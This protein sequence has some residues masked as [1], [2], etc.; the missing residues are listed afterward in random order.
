[1]SHAADRDRGLADVSRETLDVVSR[2][3]SG[4]QEP[5]VDSGGGQQPDVGSS[6]AKE[7][8][9]RLMLSAALLKAVDDILSLRDGGSELAWITAWRS[10]ADARDKVHAFIA[11]ESRVD[12]GGGEQPNVGPATVEEWEWGTTEHTHV[13]KV[14]LKEDPFPQDRRVAEVYGRTPEEAEARARLIATAPELLTDCERFVEIQSL[15]RC[16]AGEWSEFCQKIRA[17]VAK[18]RRGFTLIEL[19]VVLVIIAIVSAVALPVIV[20]AWGH[21]QLSEAARTVQG[22]FAGARDDAIHA[23]RPSGY[24]LIPEAVVTLPNGQVD[25]NAPLHASKMIPIRPAPDYSEGS[26]SIYPPSSYSAAIR[27]VNGASGVPC[28]VVEQAVLSNTGAPN[29][30]TSWFW[31]VRIGEQIQINN[32]GPW[33]TIV[34]P[35]AVKNPELFCNI[36]NPGTALPT[37]NGGSP[38]EYLLLVN[39]RDDNGNGWTDEGFDGVD[40]NGDGVVDDAAEWETERWL[41]ALGKVGP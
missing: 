8:V 37:L 18:S 5:A 4:S 13:R 22:A 27:T 9:R 10:L 15:G 3:L 21:R 20:S 29:P 2:R 16:S 23:N 12:S 34:G 1:M 39:G 14:W 11:Q 30:P 6:P 35:M 17:D 25:P 36:G 41:G 26:L 33:Y 32:A 19:L 40:N 7:I 24:R 31:N 38:C 28:L